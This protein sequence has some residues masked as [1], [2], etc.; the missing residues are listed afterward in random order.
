MAAPPPTS[1]PPL[2]LVLPSPPASPSASPAAAVPASDAVAFLA[3]QHPPAAVFS[4]PPP[5]SPSILPPTQPPPLQAPPSSS[6]LSASQPFPDEDPTENKRLRKNSLQAANA[7]SS[8]KDSRQAR[9]TLCCSGSYKAKRERQKQYLQSLEKKVKAYASIVWHPV[10]PLFTLSNDCNQPQVEAFLG[11]RDTVLLDKF[12][13]ATVQVCCLQVLSGDIAGLIFGRVGRRNI[14]TILG[15]IVDVQCRAVG[16]GRM[17]VHGL[18][19]V[20]AGEG[21]QQLQVTETRCHLRALEFWLKLG[22]EVGS[23]ESSK[24]V[25]QAE[26]A[27][28]RKRK[29]VAADVTTGD[30]FGK[31]TVI[32]KKLN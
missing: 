25:P 16:V 5:C 9:L 30:M 29:A 28:G 11:A 12:N 19:A 20:A 2:P 21:V 32:S 14:L 23:I 7:L 31:E 4:D 17:L 6:G 26:T 18:E 10:R 27:T 13:K 1:S 8:G 24:P 3:L 22:Y 15:I